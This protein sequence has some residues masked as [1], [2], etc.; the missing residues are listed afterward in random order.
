ML[1]RASLS[2]SSCL[3]LASDSNHF[4]TYVRMSCYNDVK[5]PHCHFKHIHYLPVCFDF[6]LAPATGVSSL[7][8]TQSQSHPFVSTGMLCR[9]AGENF[10]SVRLNP[11]T[12]SRLNSTTSTSLAL[13]VHWTPL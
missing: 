3:R 10:Q 1:Q 4:L 11:D 9:V 8:E 5:M 13:F 7:Q 12:L 2:N 6:V